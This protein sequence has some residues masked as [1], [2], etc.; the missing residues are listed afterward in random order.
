MRTL[1]PK[2][3]SLHRVVL[4]FLAVTLL[5]AAASTPTGQADP[6][7]YL[8]DIKSLTTP[9]MEGRGDGTKGLT[10][11][12]HL[13]E[14]RY[15]ELGLVPAGAQ[16]Y[17]QPF[18][19]ITGARLK[20]DNHLKVET[21]DVR[22]DLR[23]TQDFVPFSFSSSGQIT[24][25]IV[26]AGYGATADEFHYDD[27]ANLDVRDKIVVVLRYEPSGFAEKSGNH[28]L[29]QH[30]Q[31]I[32]KAIN[33]RNHPG[34]RN[35]PLCKTTMAD[36]SQLPNACWAHFGRPDPNCLPVPKGTSQM[37]FPTKRC[38][39]SPFSLPLSMPRSHEYSG[40]PTMSLP[41]KFV[42]T[43]VCV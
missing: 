33:A 43:L 26:F 10:R 13:I 12:E 41:R 42:T 2:Y 5:T 8:D 1:L 36:V 35:W 4:G 37:T 34:S 25:P 9:D 16:G 22:K 31:L 23:I 11:A 18:S 21:A 40:Q 3:R 15:K 27:Y 38:R 7:R 20:S 17:E 19:V 14:K 30:S 24:G 32:T 39:E 6:A 29:T 28:G